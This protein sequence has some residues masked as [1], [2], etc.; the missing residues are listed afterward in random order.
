MLNGIGRYTTRGGRFEARGSIRD[1][2]ASVNRRSAGA[3]VSRA[4]FREQAAAQVTSI[5]GNAQVMSF[6]KP[7]G[8]RQNEGLLSE[9]GVDVIALARDMFL[10]DPVAGAVVEI[11]SNLPFGDCSLSGMPSNSM[12]D[13]YR[14]SMERMRTRTLLPVAAAS[15][16]TDGAYFSS[17]MFDPEAKLFTGTIPQDLLYAELTPVPF[18]GVAPIINLRMPSQRRVAMTTAAS[19]PRMKRYMEH[20]PKD[21]LGQQSV[22]LQP[23]NTA[24][25]PRLAL[26]H[27]ATGVSFLRRI[28]LIYL[29]EKALM[30]G[31]M[32]MAY[33]RQRPIM[34]I[35]AGDETWDLGEDDMQQLMSLF[36]AADLDPVGSVVVTRQSVN[37]NEVGNIAEAWRWQDTAD[38]FNTIKL[39]GLGSPDGLL[40]GDMSI[41]SV[42]TTITV[43]M[44]QLRTFRDYFTRALFYEKLFAYLAVTNEH[45]R[46]G[47][48]FLET[49][50]DEGAIPVA[51]MAR[52]SPWSN[53]AAE[54]ETD[55]DLSDYAMPRITWHTEMRPEGDKDYLD[56][57]D[58]LSQKGVPIPI[59][60]WAAA[61]GQNI[62]DLLHGAP[63]DIRLRTELA[64]YAKQLQAINKAS[65]VSDETE[66]EATDRFLKEMSPVRP[67]GL[68]NRQFNP[69]EVS[70]ANVING[71]RYLM[72]AR[73]RK[74]R[75]DKSNAVISAASANVARRLN[76]FLTTQEVGVKPRKPVA[77]TVP[78]L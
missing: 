75:V 20:M 72:T 4:K 73:E 33:R 43:F 44:Q 27:H 51:N 58:T 31:T 32:E 40:G 64:A 57:L 21:L 26:T 62:E 48:G 13:P 7:T 47:R 11:S 9:N 60:V 38:T 3:R 59:R 55:V 67:V 10:N 74:R 37:V 28:M 29:L 54:G 71:T 18:F 14:K 22:M 56:L 36:M 24:Y 45:K 5:P 66:E 53:F 35:T 2:I 78:L 65:G 49:G 68:A 42:S 6:A 61:G 77:G 50:R 12:Y 30:R 69:D 41:D 76:K 34:H 25:I 8:A 16:L 52:V 19:D 39:K 46:E 17:L 15:F 70:E 63:E 23:E 1:E